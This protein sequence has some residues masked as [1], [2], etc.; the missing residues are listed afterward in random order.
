MLSIL[1]DQ[2]C[3]TM[4]HSDYDYRISDES[5]DPRECLTSLHY[6]ISDESNDQRECLTS[7]NCSA[8]IKQWIVI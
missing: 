8:V 5:N 7:L 6:W 1:P 3:K 2:S 4:L